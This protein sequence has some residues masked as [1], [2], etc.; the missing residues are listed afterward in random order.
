[1]AEAKKISA[2]SVLK[3]SI[4]ALEKQV[5]EMK[6]ATDLLA[7]SQG[8]PPV[9]GSTRR[10]LPNAKAAERQRPSEDFR[11]DVASS[12]ASDEQD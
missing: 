11:L 3:T 7:V 8:L 5:V 1:M 2:L 10:A 6:E 4:A 9:Y 12:F